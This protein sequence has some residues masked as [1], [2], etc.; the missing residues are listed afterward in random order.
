MAE[1]TSILMV[2]DNQE[3]FAI[4]KRAFEKVEFDIPLI[5]CKDGLDAINF[6]YREEEYEGSKN[7]ARPSLILLDLSMPGMDGYTF[8]E[9]IK[10][11]NEFR[12][13]PVIVLSVTNNKEDV[14]RSFQLGAS[15]YI[16]KP[17]DLEGYV[18]M[19]NNIK[20]YWYETS[21]LPSTTV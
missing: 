18:T 17:S 1:P 6:L 13:I 15:G 19:V 16:E 10:D 12:H 4:L 21:L 7:A 3:H 20:A 8:L 14:E 11:D 2:D 9:T 5:N